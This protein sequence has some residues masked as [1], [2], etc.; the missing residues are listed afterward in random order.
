MRCGI[1]FAKWYQRCAWIHACRYGCPSLSTSVQCRVRRGSVV[2]TLF[3]NCM[4]LLHHFSLFMDR[5]EDGSIQ[6]TEEYFPS[7]VY[8]KD[9][10]YDKDNDSE[11]LGLFRGYLLVRVYRHIFTGP[12]S[13]IIPM[14]KVNKSKAKKFNL[15]KVTGRT[16][17]Y[18]SVQVC[19]FLCL[20]RR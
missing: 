12:S 19:P 18:A 16:I 11:D 1:S 20:G 17:G 13:A 15:T 4:C 8:D 6:I 14:T 9:T 7:F 3:F 2:S 5:V 10:L